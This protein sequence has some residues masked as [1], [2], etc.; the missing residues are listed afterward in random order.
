MEA[1]RICGTYQ[2]DHPVTELWVGVTVTYGT[3]QSDHVVIGLW[4]EVTE[5]CNAY[6]GGRSEVK[7]P[8]SRLVCHRSFEE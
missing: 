7:L 1:C 6:Q 8:I 5:K 2:S 3:C 4:V